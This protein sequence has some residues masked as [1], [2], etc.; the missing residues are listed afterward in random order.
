MMSSR[1]RLSGGVP[2]RVGADLFVQVSQRSLLVM[3]P[4]NPAHAQGCHR[5]RLNP[6]PRFLVLR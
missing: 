6:T 5:S 4:V 1:E 2:K 3:E